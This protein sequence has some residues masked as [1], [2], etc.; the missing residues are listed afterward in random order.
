[1]A[2]EPATTTKKP[3]TPRSEAAAD[4]ASLQARGMFA[5][6]AQVRAAT[7]HAETRSVEAVI[8][9]ERTVTMFDWFNS[10]FYDEVLRADGLVPTEQVP[11]LNSHARWSVDDVVGSVRDIR[12]DGEQIVAR[13][14]LADVASNGETIEKVRQ[15]HLTDVSAGYR[16]LEFTIVRRGESEEIG[17]RKYTADKRPLR[18]VTKW[19]LREVSLV[20]VGADAA[21]K[22]RAENAPLE[23][24]METRSD[25]APAAP[26]PTVPQNPAA[27]AAR[28]AEVAAIKKAA[29]DEAVA[30]ERKRQADIREAARG[31]DLPAELLARA[32]AEM[33]VEQ[34]RAAF[35][36]HVREARGKPVAPGAIIRNGELTREALAFGVMMQVGAKMT[37]QQR[38][39][40][41]SASKLHLLEVC[42]HALKLDGVDPA[43]MGK[44]ELAERAAT[45]V[46][47][48]V[49]FGNVADKAVIDK[50]Q[51][52]PSTAMQWAGITDLAD[53][54]D[55]KRGRLSDVS[56]LQKLNSAGEIASLD[57][58]EWFETISV[59]TY[60]G[61]IH[62]TRADIINDD[63][64]VFN[65]LS[66][67]CGNAAKRKID[68]VFYTVLLSNPTLNDSIALFVTTATT[69]NNLMSGGTT[70]LTDANLAT[71]KQKMRQ[72]KD[73]KGSPLNLEM[74]KLLVP[75]ELEHTALK[76]C[77][78]P[79]ILR[80]G[81]STTTA[82]QYGPFNPWNGSMS[83][84][85]EPRL[86]TSSYTGYSTTAFYGICDPAQGNHMML[87]FLRGTNRSPIVTQKDPAP[88]QT[89]LVWQVLM[90]IG[91]AAVDYRGIQKSAGA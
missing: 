60:A 48:P 38:E 32:E 19:E 87:A 84:I 88:N 65:D 45:T 61:L 1:M 43:G 59:D 36:E 20:P 73:V 79:M 35:L 14:T 2:T 41:H 22:M 74:R 91:A 64:G 8:A 69:H 15:G 21:A 31:L 40:G 46:S 76:L 37:D 83:V 24:A 47:L 3:K 17:G 66:M 7:W 86:S 90:D 81:G 33:T 12:R 70:T 9:T 51:E 10:N 85:V 52:T 39:V 16:N 44:H 11:L 4:S 53:F 27:D 29:A 72:Q 18:V 42:R 75:P 80:S 34:A 58:G 6:D 13:L 28:N 71:L 57:V 78:S 56:A 62:L 55:A 54:K 25:A 26:A 5:L 30:S 77:M 67:K 63:L 68:D 82:E 50:Y 23:N 89:G 49:I